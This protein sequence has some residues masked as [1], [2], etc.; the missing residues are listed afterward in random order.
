MRDVDAIDRELAVLAVVRTA[1]RAMGANPSTKLAD[2]LLDERL[3]VSDA[4]RPV[5]DPAR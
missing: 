4:S 3:H 2:E 1:T 5:Q